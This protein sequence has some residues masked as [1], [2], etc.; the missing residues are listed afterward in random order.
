VQQGGQQYICL[1]DRTGSK[2]LEVQRGKWIGNRPSISRASRK[3]NRL[4]AINPTFQMK[5]VS[6]AIKATAHS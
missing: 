1:S 3:F 2:T 6:E 5:R 4:H